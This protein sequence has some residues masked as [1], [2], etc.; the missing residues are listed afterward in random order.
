MWRG[1][2][3]GNSG[4]GVGRGRGENQH[5][6]KNN[7]PTGNT[8]LSTDGLNEEIQ[9]TGSL[10]NT[11]DEKQETSTEVNTTL[12]PDPPSLLPR[13]KRGAAFGV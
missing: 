3:R 2:Y 11:H 8:G 5:G 9:A 12:P 1:N 4:R 13:N 10:K 7:G 6:T